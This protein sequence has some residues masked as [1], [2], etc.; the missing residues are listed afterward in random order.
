MYITFLHLLHELLFVYQNR[1]YDGRAEVMARWFF[2]TCLNGLVIFVFSAHSFYVTSQNL[3][4]E[5]LTRTPSVLKNYEILFSLIVSES[6]EYSPRSGHFHSIVL[7]KALKSQLTA[8]LITNFGKNF[9]FV[10]F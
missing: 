6:R 3:E 10:L 9:V 1:E 7:K 5:T 8:D 4:T 2:S